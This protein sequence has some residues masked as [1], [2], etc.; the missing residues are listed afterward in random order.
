MFEFEEKEVPEYVI[1]Y[2]K[3]PITL[4]T[5]HLE[6]P[7]KPAKDEIVKVNGK[8]FILI[9]FALGFEVT[10]N[11]REISRRTKFSGFTGLSA[12]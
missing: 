10:K 2:T 6:N 1:Y 9:I 5:N 11:R 3:P 4:D 8:A 12:G 7:A